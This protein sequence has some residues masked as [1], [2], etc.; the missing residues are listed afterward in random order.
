MVAGIR[1]AK[2]GKLQLKWFILNSGF[3]LLQFLGRESFAITLPPQEVFSS[4]GLLCRA[5]KLKNK[6][7]GPL[8]P[9]QM[10]DD[11]R[12]SKPGVAPCRSMTSIRE[13][14]TPTFNY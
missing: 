3:K 6:H 7:R 10:E 8:M 14:R 1:Y 2:G 4:L 5:G 13:A 12:G 9:E 11:E